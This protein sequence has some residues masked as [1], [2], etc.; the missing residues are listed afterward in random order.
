MNT[1]ET[2]NDCC[3][4]K[5]SVRLYKQYQFEFENLQQKLWNATKA[6]TTQAKQQNAEVSS[7]HVVI[8]NFKDNEISC[9]LKFK[10]KKDR[11]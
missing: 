6:A 11:N 4:W 7:I 5:M 9:D 8:N 1:F 2:K 10:T 3:C